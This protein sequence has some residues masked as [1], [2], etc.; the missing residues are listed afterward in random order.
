ME[1]R[2]FWSL[3]VTLHINWSETDIIF[4][5]VWFIVCD[6][7]RFPNRLEKRPPPDSGKRSTLEADCSPDCRQKLGRRCWAGNWLQSQHLRECLLVPEFDTQS[8]YCTHGNRLPPMDTNS[9]APFE[10]WTWFLGPQLHALSQPPPIIYPFHTYLPTGDFHCRLHL[11]SYGPHCVPLKDQSAR[12]NSRYLGH[13]MHVRILRYHDHSSGAA[14][15]PPRTT[16][17]QF[18]IFS[19]PVPIPSI[20]S[21]PSPWKL[22]IEEWNLA[23]K[24]H[25]G[26][27]LQQ[28][29]AEP[30]GV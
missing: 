4:P 19:I 23:S 24:A 12:R 13:C 14:A 29:S 18:R 26:L 21:L 11:L 1:S 8:H 25:N 27:F 3:W 22:G 10:R 28:E 16:K 7:D 2:V 15:V 9:H 30:F 6:R 20:V 17:R 5:T